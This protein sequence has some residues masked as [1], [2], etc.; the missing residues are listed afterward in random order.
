MKQAAEFGLTR[1]GQRVAALLMFITDVHAL[2]LEAA[3]GLV[4]S[5]SFYWDMNDR[6][7]AFSAR[8]RANHGSGAPTMVA[9]RLL[10]RDPALPEGGGRHG[11]RRGPRPMAPRRSPG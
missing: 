4:C 8:M 2:G 9:G 11:R 3:Q 5:E 7:R 6:T 10:C 1:R